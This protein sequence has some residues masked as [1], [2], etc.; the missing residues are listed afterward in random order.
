MRMICGPSKARLLYHI[1]GASLRAKK[2]ILGT[3]RLR[4]FLFLH[5]IPVM[6]SYCARGTR[7]AMR[8]LTAPSLTARSIGTPLIDFVAQISGIGFVGCYKRGT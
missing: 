3:P 6:A 8:F 4:L 2:V 1:R 7:L 5:I